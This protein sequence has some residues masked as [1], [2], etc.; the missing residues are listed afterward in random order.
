[1]REG[2]SPFGL[3][4]S[5]SSGEHGFR[6]VW[7]ECVRHLIL[8]L[9]EASHPCAGNHVDLVAYGKV[10]CSTAITPAIEDKKVSIVPNSRTPKRTNAERGERL[11]SGIPIDKL[12]KHQK[13]SKQALHAMREIERQRVGGS[14]FWRRLL[15]AVAFTIFVL[16][17][18]YLLFG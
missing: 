2:P 5:R 6:T 17:L 8:K 11:I 13:E 15:P 12:Q 18:R 14:F 10:Y 4:T 16:L 9:K 3:G 1:M 7:R